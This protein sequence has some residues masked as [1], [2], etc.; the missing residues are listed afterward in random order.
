MKY[1]FL[2]SSSRVNGNSETL[3]RAA[4][5]SLPAG[6]EATWLRLG[7]HP[8]PPFEDLRHSSG[9]GDPEGTSKFLLEATLEADH[10][11]FVTPVYWYSVSAPLKRYLDEW[12]AWL[13]APSANF[14]ARMA[15]KTYCAI[16]STSGDAEHAAPTLKTLEFC[17]E[18]F[19]ALWRGALLGNGSKPGDVLRDAAALEAA[20]TFF[21]REP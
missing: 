7:D 17:A 2:L 18:Y 3:A 1:L 15:Q 14:R 21:S 13:R 12:S 5:E 11:V 19:S 9:Y 16:V 4:A 6:A 8:L 20:K 10:V